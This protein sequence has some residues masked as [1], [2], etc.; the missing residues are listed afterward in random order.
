MP[1]D[2]PS[3]ESDEFDPRSLGPDA[4]RIDL[5]DL[6]ADA[7]TDDGGD[8]DGTGSGAS[9]GNGDR[10][11]ERED[12]ADATGSEDL[13]AA[14]VDPETAELFW[15]L[16][17]TFDVA[18]P[19]IALGTLFVYFDGRLRV[20]FAL[21]AAGAVLFGWGVLRAYRFNR[22]DDAGAV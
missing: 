22:G 5:P 8:A 12:G 2:D 1:P 18:L 21:T 9:A 6:A 10:P 17:V 20:G 13:T 14:D 19:A 16:V 7:D 3:T 11:P 15:K 4:P